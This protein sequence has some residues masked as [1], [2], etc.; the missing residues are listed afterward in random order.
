MLSARDSSGSLPV[1]GSKS[2][3]LSLIL[4]RAVLCVRTANFEQYTKIRLQDVP[5]P[6]YTL[7][8]IVENELQRKDDRTWTPAQRPYV[9]CF[10]ST[11]T[12]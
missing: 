7:S 8:L 11:D 1:M 9:P 6:H 2:G 5:K 12:P 3:S 10:P 4:D